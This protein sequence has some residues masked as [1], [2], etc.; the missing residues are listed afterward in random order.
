MHIARDESRRSKNTA[1]LRIKSLR[2]QF[3]VA[4]VS[5]DGVT[6]YQHGTDE[7]PPGVDPL[8]WEGA[9]DREEK[10]KRLA[11]QMGMNR[12]RA[13]PSKSPFKPSGAVRTGKA[14]PRPSHPVTRHE[15]AQTHKG[16]ASSLSAVALNASSHALLAPGESSS[17]DEHESDAHDTRARN[18]TGATGIKTAREDATPPPSP[19]LTN[20]SSQA[21]ASNASMHGF[22]SMSQLLCSER[23]SG[24]KVW[25]APLDVDSI[26]VPT[27]PLSLE[28]DGHMMSEEQLMRPGV[29][30]HALHKL[31]GKYLR[32]FRET[33]MPDMHTVQ[34]EQLLDDRSSTYD[35]SFVHGMESYAERPRPQSGVVRVASVNIAIPPASATALAG[36]HLLRTT[37][38]CPPSLPSQSQSDAGSVV[39]DGRGEDT[40]PHVQRTNVFPSPFVSDKTLTRLPGEV[41]DEYYEWRLDRVRR[42]MRTQGGDAA[43]VATG[44]SIGKAAGAGKVNAKGMWQMNMA[45]KAAGV[46]HA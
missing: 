43:S 3:R 23:G 31:K 40:T 45:S 21:G 10:R 4:S 11:A 39:S 44:R 33:D 20:D 5:S 17:Q 35:G 46:G 16:V 8:F 6:T 18:A 30:A 32:V 15:D 26:L 41:V 13:Q 22:P 25:D 14:V 9:A 37:M 2:R 7:V 28:V 12:T 27:G 34:P 42:Q 36:P 38:T 1:K 19:L 29:A 24:D